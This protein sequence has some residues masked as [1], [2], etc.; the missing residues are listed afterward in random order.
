MSRIRRTATMQVMPSTP[1]ARPPDLVHTSDMDRSLI[2]RFV[3]MF[4][5]P[6]RRFAAAFAVLLAM[7]LALAVAAHG[8]T[9]AGSRWELWRTGLEPAVIVYI[10]G[11]H[12]LLHRRWTLAIESLRSLVDRPE[13]VAE[14]RWVDRR[15]EWLAVLVGSA[16]GVWDATTWL[17]AG[18]WIFAYMLVTDVVMFGLMALTIY[19]GFGRTRYLSRIVRRDVQ[20]DL[21]DRRP[22]VPLARWG[23][24]VSLTFVGGICLSLFFQS[25]RMLVSVNAIVI[26]SILVVVSLSL[27]FMSIWS[28]HGALVAAQQRELAIV[29]R[30]RERARDALKQGLEGAGTDAAARLYEPVVVFG[31]YE[32]QVLEASTWPFD[33]KVIKQLAAST[34]APVVLYI[35][36]IAFGLSRAP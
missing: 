26:Y 23:Q 7:L 10:L 30:H 36:K 22:L 29:T 14:V 4:G 20:F 1:I 9:P 18:P 12:P 24:S 8:Y 15:G 6:Q 27:F 2:D 5:M 11:V 17:I 35:A 3:A 21:F 34:I 33:P 19:D 28:I 31:N 13:L 25:Y 32:R 16:F